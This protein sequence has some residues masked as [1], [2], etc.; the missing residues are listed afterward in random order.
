VPSLK[1]KVFLV[2]GATDNIG[3]FTARKLGEAGAKVLIHGWN[4][5][6]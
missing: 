2:T 6:R 5:N 3:R 4:H 1:D